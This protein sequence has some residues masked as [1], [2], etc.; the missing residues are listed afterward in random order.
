MTDATVARTRHLRTV[1]AMTITHAQRY[2]ALLRSIG[3]DLEHNEKALT[4]LGAT[5]LSRHWELLDP[6]TVVR[7]GVLHIPEIQYNNRRNVARSLPLARSFLE[8][9]EGESGTVTALLGF[10]RGRI[11]QI[12][13]LHRLALSELELDVPVT[14]E[15]LPAI[16]LAALIEV[17]PDADHVHA[18]LAAAGLPAQT[19]PGMRR[20]SETLNDTIGWVS[21]QTDR[22][23][24]A[25]FSQT[26]TTSVAR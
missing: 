6:A 14:L 17:A 3:S 16:H 10:P 2:E 13:E 15:S 5:T 26:T 19:A 25:A 24:Q 11:G 8:E 9:L 1:R 4:L 21:A 22:F 23:L 18:A 20:R 12:V 7:A